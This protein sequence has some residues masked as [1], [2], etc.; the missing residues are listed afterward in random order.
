MHNGLAHSELSDVN[1][2]LAVS[3]NG[4]LALAYAKDGIPVFPCTAKGARVKQPLTKHGHH[5]ASSDIGTVQEWWTK[6][7]DA[8]VGIPAGPP[9]GL[10]VLDV[11]GDAGLRNLHALLLRLGLASVADL[12]RC[13]SRTPGGGLHLIFRWQPGERPRN[14]AK[15]IGDCLDSRGVKADGTSAGYFIAPGSRLPTGA[16]YELI[17]ASNI[18]LTGGAK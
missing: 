16:S 6:W 12:T 1:G 3:A 15:D 17:D 2:A 10:W 14:R 18:D 7:P 9:S 4:V 8:L 13:V 11:D 5:D